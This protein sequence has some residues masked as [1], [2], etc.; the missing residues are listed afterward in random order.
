MERAEVYPNHGR[1]RGIVAAAVFAIVA[2]VGGA[3][4]IRAIGAER[5][6]R[7]AAG[8]TVREIADDPARYYG[9]R[10]TVSGAVDTLIGPRAFTIGGRRFLGGQDL[11]I[12]GRDPLPTVAERPGTPGPAPADVVQVTGTVRQ[13][14]L[15]AFERELGADLDDAE[16]ANRAGQPAILATDVRLT[17]RADTAA[18]VPPLTGVTVAAV[19]NA[20]RQFVGQELTLRGE[21]DAVIGRQAFTIGDGDFVGDDRLLI[22]SNTPLPVISGRP[23]DNPLLRDDLVRVTGTLRLFDPAAAERELGVDLDEASL[24]DWIGQPAIIARGLSLTPR[25]STPGVYGLPVSTA[26]LTADPA[27]FRGETVVVSGEI[28]RL[29]GQG[30]FVLNDQVLVTYIEA[31]VPDRTPQVGQYVLVTGPFSQFDLA[32]FER[33]IGRDLPDARFSPFSGKPAVGAA[34]IRPAR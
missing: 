34:T 31:P 3:L 28:T 15:A 19:A 27:A 21:V 11:L 22:L 12:V 14:G 17:P 8:A 20:P 33:E 26:D 23:P 2:L 7:P 29:L 16:L 4:V 6:A 18:G 5:A 24:R 1:R 10:V 25:P 32:T 30:A 9:Q 13:F